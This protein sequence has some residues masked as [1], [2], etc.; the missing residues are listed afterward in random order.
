MKGD[1]I[2][3]RSVVWVE[4]S[5]PCVIFQVHRDGHHVRQEEIVFLQDLGIRLRSKK[6]GRTFWEKH[7][8]AAVIVG[9]CH[10]ACE[11]FTE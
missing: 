9:F 5:E 6:V 3:I 1:W 2:G 10:H 8:I 7:A 4:N 11:K